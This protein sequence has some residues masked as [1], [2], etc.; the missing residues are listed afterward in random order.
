MDK[1]AFLD[2]L[3]NILDEDFMKSIEEFYQKSI[4]NN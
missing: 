2:E 4:A 1:N 3:A